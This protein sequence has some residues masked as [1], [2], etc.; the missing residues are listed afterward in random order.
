MKRS[1]MIVL[2]V[3]M[4]VLGAIGAVGAASTTSVQTADVQNDVQ[5]P[6]YIASIKAPQ[7]NGDEAQEA[8][9]LESYAKITPKD[10]EN[11]A[12]A[13]VPGKVVKVSLDNENGY[14]VYSVEIS[15]NAGVKDVKVDAGT[16]Q[17]LHIDSG[18]DHESGEQEITEE[19]E[20]ALETE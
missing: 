6:G 9:A 5:E 12:L 1:Y 16:G 3:A 7:M 10:A 11:A 19:Q 17:V 4:A 15:T 13:K 8:K 18:D 2:L 20:T 14:V